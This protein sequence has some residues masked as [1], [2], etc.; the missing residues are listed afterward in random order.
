MA[1]SFETEKEIIDIYKGRING[2]HVERMEALGLGFVLG[3]RE[4]AKI[5]D[6]S[7]KAYYD[8]HCSGGQYVLGHRHP[9]MV[10]AL[11]EALKDLDL[12]NFVMISTQK[13]ALA[14]LLADTAPGDLKCVVYGVGRG[15]SNEFAMKLVRGFT[16]REE[17]VAFKG[18]SHGQT[19]FALS[20][21]DDPQREKMFGPLIPQIKH[22]PLDAAELRKAVSDKTAAVIVEPIQ[23]DAGVVMLPDGFLAEARKVCDQHGAALIFDEGATS[24][25][26]TGKLFECERD[27]VTP[28]ILVLGR[29][30]GG[31]MYPITAAVFTSRLNRFLLT[32]P[33][34]HLSTF[35]GADVGCM[36]AMA[37]IRHIVKNKLWENAEAQ[38]K[39]LLDGLSGI[40]AAHKDK[41][42]G[43]RGAGLL[44]GLE[45]V[46][47]TAADAYVKSLAANG[48]V[49][50]PAPGAPSVIRFTPPVD[51][52]ASEIDAILAAAKAA[53][54]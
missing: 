3:K 7:G 31:T 17:I 52:T 13:G 30:L 41:F 44:I 23:S 6:M 26:R 2:P 11:R 20:A 47:P 29:G 18:G 37:A 36:V 24:L 22:I 15:E 4:G 43:A 27:C 10:A 51:V 12:G 14:K 54:V 8:C 34:I 50:L 46:G 16:G 5:Y 9:D 49:A 39:R 53:A 38:G 21:S 25:G 32:H 40:A 35:G 48:V 42:V 45:A 28:D 19:G 33:L 1:Q